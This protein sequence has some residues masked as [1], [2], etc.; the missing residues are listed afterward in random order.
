M[1]AFPLLDIVDRTQNMTISID[2]SPIHSHPDHHP[3][4]PSSHFPF[5]LPPPSK[6]PSSYTSS[7]YFP[8]SSLLPPSTTLPPT[9]HPPLTL[10]PSSSSHPPFSLLPPSS[11]PPSY[12]DRVFGEPQM[13]ILLDSEFSKN[14]PK[15]NP[16]NMIETTSGFMSHPAKRSEIIK[17]FSNVE[18]A[19]VEMSLL[20]QLS[21]DP[22]FV[23]VQSHFLRQT[24]EKE[25]FSIGGAAVGGEARDQNEGVGGG[26]RGGEGEGEGDVDDVERRGGYPKIQ[27]PL[28]ERP[29]QDQQSGSKKNIKLKTKSKVPSSAKDKLKYI[30]DDKDYERKTRQFYFEMNE[31]TQLS[32]AKTDE[33]PKNLRKFN[34]IPETPPLE[35]I[36]SL[37]SFTSIEDKDKSVSEKNP[38]LQTLPPL[39]TQPQRSQERNKQELDLAELNRAFDIEKAFGKKA[40][41]NFSPSAQKIH[42]ESIILVCMDCE[43][44]LLMKDCDNHYRECS[45]E[46]SCRKS[47]K[48]TRQ[49]NTEI[50][51]L[52]EH[53][54]EIVSAYE[55]KVE[56][57]RKSP[58]FRQVVLTIVEESLI[59][60]KEAIKIEVF[61][62]ITKKLRKIDLLLKHL[63]THE[64]NGFYFDF[65][66]LINRLYYLCKEKSF[67]LK[68][69]LANSG[70]NE[71]LDPMEYSMVYMADNTLQNFN[72]NNTV[73]YCNKVLEQLNIIKNKPNFLGRK[74]NPIPTQ[75]QAVCKGGEGRKGIEEGRGGGKNVASEVGGGEKVIGVDGMKGVGGGERAG[76]EEREGEGGKLDE[77]NK[78]REFFSIALELKLKYGVGTEVIVADLYKQSQL[79]GVR[80]GKWGEWL[81]MKMKMV[82]L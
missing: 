28:K 7:S 50:K 17:P 54:L 46:A 76:G 62:L 63:E 33:F 48:W 45:G 23:N 16:H 52:N 66:S 82:K 72:M 4:S 26:K 77:E 58:E 57:F 22:K 51:V 42:Q 14:F 55:R 78:K 65:C 37:N 43:C 2:D 67:K 69:A 80:K 47:S 13:E 49:N 39:Q 36:R 61:F 38:S 79:E 70:K 30:E 81:E 53:M 60:F 44:S 35:S 3:S 21:T 34:Q 75:P 74:Q 15:S 31:S 8:P 32:P 27:T 25:H 6:F 18:S 24:S 19:S 5:P 20:K 64:R 68:F 73:D 71:N 12:L 11:A 10:L 29:P 9:Y 56:Q 41:K 1:D 59:L 40:K